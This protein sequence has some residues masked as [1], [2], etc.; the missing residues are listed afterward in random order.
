MTLEYLGWIIGVW[1]V[2]MV[3]MTIR[4]IVKLFLP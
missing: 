1:A 2:V 4:L 3:L